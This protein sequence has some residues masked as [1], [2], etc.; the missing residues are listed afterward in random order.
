[1]RA[2]CSALVQIVASAFEF[3]GGGGVWT[4]WM[5]GTVE[6]DTM[7]REGERMTVVCTQT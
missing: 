6:N 3:G 2:E 4:F 5:Q 7:A 1:M